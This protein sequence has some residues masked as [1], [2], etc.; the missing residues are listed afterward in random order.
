MA[1]KVFI[2]Y[3]SREAIAAK[4]LKHSIE[5]HCG[6]DIDVTFLEHREL[7]KQG[8]FNRP[9]LIESDTGDYRDLIDNKPFSTEFS[10]TRFLVPSLCG[11]EGWALFLDCDMV[12]RT[13]IR[14]LFALAEPKCAV[15][16]VK[17]QQA[18]K[19]NEKKMDGRL[20]ESYPMKNWS[21]FMLFNCAHP[22]NRKLTEDKVSQA[23]GGWMHQFGWLPFPGLVGGLPASYNYIPR[24]SSPLPVDEID[25]VHYTFGGPWFDNCRDVP[26][27]DIWMQEYEDYCREADH[28]VGFPSVKFD[29]RV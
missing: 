23:R 10:H 17:H 8:A 13:D 7:R 28:S 6:V 21:S 9:W 12:F 11:F 2:G 25:C 15:Q 16:V 18:V 1:L 5:R 3:D 29:R 27:A 19:S 22:E 20:N 26:L 24:V 4:V 14:K